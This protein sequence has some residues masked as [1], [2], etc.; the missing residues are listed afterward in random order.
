MRIISG[1]HKG[2]RIIAPKNLPIRPT[3]DRSKEGLFNILHH[4]IDINSTTVLDLFSGAGNI[5]YEFASRGAPKITSVDQNRFCVKF[6]Q[7]TNQALGFNISVI[8]GESLSFLEKN[9]IKYDLIF[10][11]PPYDWNEIAYKKI[12]LLS[13]KLLNDDGMLI[14]EHNK[15][16]NISSFEGFDFSRAYGDSV[17]SFFK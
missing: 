9:I 17:F 4:R 16:L 3:T 11:D 6:I 1:S 10:A 13:Q 2:R 5:S 15:F 7:K 8:K 14:L 12:V